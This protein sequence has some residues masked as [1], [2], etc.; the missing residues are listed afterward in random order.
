M[1]RHL[2]LQ[3]VSA[4]IGLPTHAALEVDSDCKTRCAV[5]GLPARGLSA[6]ASGDGLAARPSRSIAGGNL[7]GICSHTGK[8]TRTSVSAVLMASLG[9]GRSYRGQ[10]DR[11]EI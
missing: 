9:R 11:R 5:H 3:L 8:R 2:T 10:H 4:T 7:N 1:K 6:A